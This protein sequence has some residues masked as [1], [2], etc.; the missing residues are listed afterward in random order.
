MQLDQPQKIKKGLPWTKQGD[1]FL[2]QPPYGESYMEHVHYKEL[3]D[4]LVTP[5]LRGILD[6]TF[7]SLPTM[8][9]PSYNPLTGN[10]LW[11]PTLPEPLCQA[12]LKTPFRQP[13]IALK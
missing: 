2:L 10:P 12:G 3:C 9:T 5:P 8:F 7:M 1:P 4:I 11:N 6:G 13:P